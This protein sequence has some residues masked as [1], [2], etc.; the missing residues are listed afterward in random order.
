MSTAEVQ[1]RYRANLKKKKEAAAAAVAAFQEQQKEIAAGTAQSDKAVTNI[2]REAWGLSNKNV[3]EQCIANGKERAHDLNVSADMNYWL[4]GSEAEHKIDVI[5]GRSEVLSM[6]D[7]WA[8]YCFTARGL[9]VLGVE[10]SFEQ[11]LDLRDRARKD[12]WFLACD[13]LGIRLVEEVHREIIDLIYPSLNCDGMFTLNYTLPDMF[14]AMDRQCETKEHMILDPREWLKSL[15]V[16]A[17]VLQFMLNFPEAKVFNVSGT[18]DLALASIQLQKG[19]LGSNE[20][21][22]RLFPEYTLRGVDSSSDAPIYL[23][24]RRFHQKDPSY[25]TFSV[26]SKTSGKHCDLYIGDDQVQEKGTE[27][28]RAT[29]KE[30]ADS[31]LSNVPSA[32]AIKIILGT[33]YDLE[34][35]YSGRIALLEADPTSMKFHSRGVMEILPQYADVPYRDLTIDMVKLNWP[36]RFGSPEKTFKAYMRKIVTNESDFRH[37]QMNTPISAEDADNKIAFDMDAFGNLF[38]APNL[39]PQEGDQYLIVDI[40]WSLDKRADFSVLCAARIG[41]SISSGSEQS[42]YV[43]EV[44]AA[45]RRTSELAI[46][47]V[48]ASMRHQFTS[49]IIEKIGGVEGVIDEVRR[50]AAIRNHTLPFIYAAPVLTTSGAKWRRIKI[51]EKYVAQSRLWFA[52]SISPTQRALIF[53][54]F[55][56]YTGKR[57]STRHD[58]I[59]DCVAILVEVA[60]PKENV[61]GDRQKE[62]D[63]ARK[64]AQEEMMRQEQYNHIFGRP[65]NLTPLQ[66]NY[67][68][69]VEIQNPIHQQLARGGKVAD[70][71]KGRW[72]RTNFGSIFQ[73]E[74]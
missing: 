52:N 3:I 70:A 35:W 43:H 28:T 20:N 38:I 23:P 17:F 21:V 60:L 7:L 40:A 22:L 47:I 4:D 44:N 57:S 31:L 30:K 1:A 66:I 32:H 56:K 65:G 12:L 68:T 54:Q 42:V 58:D 50:Q 14:A 74:D 67:D 62:L 49:I 11:W 29:L 45:R 36:N 63:D 13:I 5:G 9:K 34:D 64:N 25:S 10:L 2:F 46:A 69:P 16:S 72:V 41:K 19:Y 15:V 39:F 8:L 71:R 48:E 24:C 55:G 26:M 61:T 6:R 51:L 37:Q 18:E 33:R 73:P 53:D 59:P 27:T